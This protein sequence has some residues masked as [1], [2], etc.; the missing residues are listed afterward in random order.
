MRPVRFFLFI[1]PFPLL[2]A[3]TSCVT[4]IPAEDVAPVYY[5]LG[6]AYFE[7][8][9]PDDAVEAYLKALELDS[10]L[11]T[12]NYNLAQVYIQEEK[13]E[14]AEA[15]LRE[16]LDKDPDNE[17]ILSTLAYVFSLAGEF[18]TSSEF[19]G[20]VIERDPGNINALYNLGILAWDR[21]EYQKAE[22]YFLRI[23]EIDPD[24]GDTLYSL[25][26]VEKELENN[27][28]AIEFLEAYTAL[29]SDDKDA[30]RTLAD[31]YFSEN[32]YA[33]AMEQYDL[34]VASEEYAG[35]AYFQKAFINLLAIGDINAGLEDLGKA[36]DAGFTDE[37][38]IIRLLNHPDLLEK[39]RVEKILEERGLFPSSEALDSALDV[40]HDSP[41]GS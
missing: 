9:R 36:F 24:D 34:L 17:Q 39:E 20:R 2:A 41:G 13:Y 3:L 12:A 16:L 11:V 14:E 30:V 21:E 23:F 1:I 19:Y 10:E 4:G 6:N 37:E 7:M 33:K 26:L 28:K 27:E 22:D 18:G 32:Y 40:V 38:K 15:L 31:L 5:N 35:D 8:D 25:G 29:Q